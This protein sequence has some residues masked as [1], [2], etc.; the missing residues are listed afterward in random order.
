M[1]AFSIGNGTNGNGIVGGYSSVNSG[2]MST[3]RK[4]LKLSLDK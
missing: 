2:S 1:S 4:Q 3:N